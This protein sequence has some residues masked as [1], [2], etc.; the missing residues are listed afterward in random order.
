MTGGMMTIYGRSLTLK[1]RDRLWWERNSGVVCDSDGKID[2]NRF[3]L[4]NRMGSFLFGAIDCTIQNSELVTLPCVAA[5][6]YQCPVFIYFHVNSRFVISAWNEP[7]SYYGDANG[8]Y[9]KLTNI[10][11]FHRIIS[12]LSSESNRFLF[13]QITHHYETPH[14]Q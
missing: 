1:I 4:A 6:L 9:Q 12:K 2:S 8:F 3:V 5:H 11:Q 13:C 14:D 10:K 7:L